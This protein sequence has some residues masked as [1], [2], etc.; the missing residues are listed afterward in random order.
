MRLHRTPSSWKSNAVVR[1]RPQITGQ[2]KGERHSAAARA[3]LTRRRA[4]EGAGHEQDRERSDCKRGGGCRH[5]GGVRKLRTGGEPVRAHTRVRRLGS[6]RD[7][8]LH[9]GARHRGD[10]VFPAALARGLGTEQDPERTGHRARRRV[11]ATPGH[12][13][14]ASR[15]IQGRRHGDPRWR[16][17]R[18]AP[19]R[20]GADRR[21]CRGRSRA[22]RRS[23]RREDPTGT[24]LG[25]GKGRSYDRQ[26]NARVRRRRH[27]GAENHS[28]GRRG[29]GEH[30]ACRGGAR[31][32]PGDHLPH[33]RRRFP[34]PR[35]PLGAPRSRS[36]D[37]YQRG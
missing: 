32:R 3:P 25:R 18:R 17:R 22:E 24:D 1:G 36:T 27:A 11:G 34:N 23:L 2:W 12:G 33:H 35:Q 19:T 30:F 28:G 21:A 5:C 9:P 8:H 10:V 16:I 15:G 6:G 14:A 20:A 31:S 26:S 13:G 29:V 4:G 37:R 7:H